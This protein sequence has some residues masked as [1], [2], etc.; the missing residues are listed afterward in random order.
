MGKTAFQSERMDEVSRHSSAARRP[1][2]VIF[3]SLVE[4]DFG[5][6]WIVRRAEM[7]TVRSFSPA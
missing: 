3:G 7:G 4:I 1:W 2:V 5:T 6:V